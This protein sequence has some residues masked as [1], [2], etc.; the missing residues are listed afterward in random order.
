MEKQV[1]KWLFKYGQGSNL[2]TNVKKV[3]KKFNLSLHESNILVR[4]PTT[5]LYFIG[6]KW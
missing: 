5:R 4:I 6:R 3:M 1:S 2:I